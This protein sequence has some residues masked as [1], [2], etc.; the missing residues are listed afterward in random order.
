[1]E[2]EHTPVL[3]NETMD[4][5]A[6][7]KDGIY[8]D[9][10]AGGGGHSAGICER[11]SENGLLIAV[12]RDTEALAAAEARLKDY[13]C[14]KKLLHTNYSDIEAIEEAAGGKVDGILL[15]LGVSSYQLDN[16]DRGFSYM[17]DAPLDMRMDEGDRMTAYDV[18]NGYDRK[19][20]ARVIREY[21]EENWAD[22]IAEFIVKERQN[23]PIET[24]GALTEVIKAAIPA[25]ARRTGPHP[26][27]RT[28]QA[29]RIEV[30]DELGHLREAVER[31]P[32]LLESG[33][34]IA[35]IS[36]HSLEDRIV[37]TEFD[38]R[39]NPCTCP[40]EF[41]VCVC[42]RV[43]D[44]KKVSRKPITASEEELESNPRARSAKLRVLEKL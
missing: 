30:N 18:V 14:R 24:T 42:G 39:L 26:A 41:P 27:K 15:D 17:K 6:V 19:E 22:R 34:R 11:L 4:A 7:K 43:A 5:L 44:V 16:P 31:L 10:T 35:I 21:G 8:V 29:I 25:R 37:K 38:R 9:G 28:F 2:F 40:K 32:D 20:L 12:D 13:K 33:G 23:A 36:F 3:F 1:M